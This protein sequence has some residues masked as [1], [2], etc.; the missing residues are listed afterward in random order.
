MINFVKKKSMAAVVG[1]H[2]KP[3]TQIHTNSVSPG[4]P[5]RGCRPCT[6]HAEVA[7]NRRLKR[8]HQGRGLTMYVLRPEGNGT[9]LPCQSCIGMLMNNNYQFVVCT[10]DGNLEKHRVS[11]LYNSG[12]CRPSNGDRKRNW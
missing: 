9:S 5:V 6:L 1:R 10:V 2:G 8:K 3:Y 11:D 7:V 12:V 4:A